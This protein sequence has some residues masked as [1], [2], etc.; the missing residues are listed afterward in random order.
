[1]FLAVALSWQGDGAVAARSEEDELSGAPVLGP[2]RL[3]AVI[4][5]KS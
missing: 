4:T 5:P 3:S 1:V 2:K